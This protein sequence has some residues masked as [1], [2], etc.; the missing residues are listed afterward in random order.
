MRTR[1][2]FAACFS[3]T[4]VKSQIN[5]TAATFIEGGKTIV[6]L[7]RIFKSTSPTRTHLYTIDSCEIRS[8]GDL[9]FKNLTKKPVSIKLFRRE[10]NSYDSSGLILRVPA[11]SSEWFFELRIG[12][13]KYRMETDTNGLHS[14]LREG[15]LKLNACDKLLKEIAE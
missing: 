1:L 13:Y 14:I 15:E 4:L 9:G 5:N 11:N 6:E 2:L 8:Q 10:G 3:L 12:I 7:I